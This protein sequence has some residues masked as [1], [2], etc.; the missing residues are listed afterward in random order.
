MTAENLTR[1]KLAVV[2]RAHIF[3]A[4]C[5]ALVMAV[6][7]IASAPAARAAG[8]PRVLPENEA[9]TYRQIFALQSRAQMDA[10]SRLA[11][12]LSDKRL[13]GHVLAQR[14]LHPTAYRS[15]YK[16]LKLW[17]DQ[18]ADH[19]DADRIYALALRKRASSQ[20]S[21]RNPVAAVRRPGL[22]LEQVK[23]YRPAAPRS[24]AAFQQIAAIRLHLKSLL[25]KSDPDSAL[26]YLRRDDVSRR[27]DAVETD[28][29]RQ[30]IAAAYFYG[31][32]DLEAL[33]L[34]SEAALRSGE[35]VPQA[36]WIAGLS[37]WRMGRNELAAQNFSAMAD[38]NSPYADKASL[39]AAAY[40]AARAHLAVRQPQNV[41][42][43]LQAA[44]RHP[45]TMYGL[46][47]HRQLGLDLPF[48]WDLPQLTQADLAALQRHPALLRMLALHEAGQ[49]ALAGQEMQLLH[50][51]L[52]KE[53]AGR[54]LALAE[55]M[56]LPE[57]QIRIAESAGGRTLLAG[58]YP[59]PG[60]RPQG[61]FTLDPALLFAITRQ[62]SK[63]IASAEGRGGARGLMQLM[64]AT[65]RFISYDKTMNAAGRQRLFD[66]EY[67]L[68]LGQ[69]YIKHLQSQ[70]G[71]GDLFSLIASYNAG[72]GAVENWR[73]RVKTKDPL[74]FL[75]SL[76]NSQTRN[77]VGRVMADYWIY[78]DRMGSPGGSSLDAVAGGGWPHLPPVTAAGPM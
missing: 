23:E 20:A 3:R 61:G 75:E 62:E 2:F 47:A 64:P 19:P 72:P 24:K 49:T 76:P 5:A 59:M 17:L 43:Y 25:K 37:A 18:Y 27:L 45:Q 78:R 53:N 55:V 71:P 57:S 58:L 54:L 77:Y 28:M 66:P 40:W 56:K 11:G 31:G 35:F 69:R 63:F 21:P 46:L 74:L 52:G 29:A 44:A 4:K 51:R 50:G 41:N 48:E 36:Y 15:S 26:V 7:W 68:T 32:R 34:A 73:Q 10:A 60:W 13:L 33:R 8:L 16:E 70:L 14:Y 67:N 30:A 22:A 38:A 12:E 6:L 39:T 42:R 1:D 9:Q 65:A